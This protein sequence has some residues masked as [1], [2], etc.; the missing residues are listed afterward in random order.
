MSLIT[1]IK[2]YVYVYHNVHLLWLYYHVV[3]PWTNYIY[4]SIIYVKKKELICVL[5]WLFESRQKSLYISC[6]LIHGF[7][8]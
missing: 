3:S 8:L 7:E 2:L 6:S 5:F 1:C 4:M